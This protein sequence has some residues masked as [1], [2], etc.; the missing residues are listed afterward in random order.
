MRPFACLLVGASVI[1]ALSL[2]LSIPAA[3]AEGEWCGG[4]T[5][6]D[7][8][9]PIEGTVYAAKRPLRLQL[10]VPIN[11]RRLVTGVQ[12]SARLTFG[13]QANCT[14]NE[15]SEVF[16]DGLRADTI[17]T[18]RR[19]SASCWNRLP[20]RVRIGCGHTERCPIE[21]RAD[22]SFLYESPPPSGATA[23]SV[24][25]SRQRVQVVS[26]QGF[27]E[28]TV[29][30][31]GGVRRASGGGSSESRLVIEIVVVTK[32]IERR[33]VVISEEFAKISSVVRDPSVDDC[34]SS[35]VQEEEEVVS[36]SGP[37]RRSI[38]G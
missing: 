12:S 13:D 23:S 24:T 27:V 29:R 7:W 34:E 16:P 11:N 32:T 31:P 28:V 35:A 5:A 17:F 14:L 9:C 8:I 25:I 1:L 10:P 19:G 2:P 36:P 6:Q 18:Q 4:D 26:C 21:L 37:P 30:T 3:K 15:V 20:S 38:T 22:G 33:G